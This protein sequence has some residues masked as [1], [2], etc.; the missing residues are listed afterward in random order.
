MF[1]SILRS[2][3]R[4]PHPL[5]YGPC[6]SQR[7]WLVCLL[8]WECSCRPSL[9]GQSRG[10]TNTPVKSKELHVACLVYVYM[11]GNYTMNEPGHTYI[12]SKWNIA[13]PHFLA[14]VVAALHAEKFATIMWAGVPPL[15]VQVTSHISYIYPPFQRL[16]GRQKRRYWRAPGLL[17]WRMGWACRRRRT[18]REDSAA[19]CAGHLRHKL[20]HW[21]HNP[22]H[23][24]RW[25][26][27][28]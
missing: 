14:K 6:Q 20:R 16:S 4:L 25:H 22:P 10:W 11:E 7:S 21:H 2:S 9:C 24:Y 19:L 1:R 27:F 12:H 3:I 13:I 18:V 26:N 17:G 8:R 28:P 5:L 23:R 15:Q